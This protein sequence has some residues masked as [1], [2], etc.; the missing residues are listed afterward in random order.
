MSVIKDSK[1][2]VQGYISAIRTMLDNYPELKLNNSLLSLLNSNSPFGFIMNLLIIC[3]IDEKKLLNWCAKILCGS[4]VL[5]ADDNYEKT[6]ERLKNNKSSTKV[7]Q[8]ILDVIEYSIKTLLL[9]N[10]KDMFTCSI[11]PFIPNEVMKYPKDSLSNNG[12]LM[13]SKGIEISIPTIDMFNVLSHAPNGK[14]GK[15]LYFDN[16]DL[17]PNQM[18]KS[19]DFNA[20]LWYVINKGNDPFKCIWDNRCKN[21]VKKKIFNE[22]KQR[23]INDIFTENF[24]NPNAGDGCYIIDTSAQTFNEYTTKDRSET[25]EERKQKNS[26]QKKQYILVEYEENSTTGNVP[27][28]LKFYVNADRYRKK[29]KVGERDVFVNKTVFEFNYDYIFS[30]KLFDSKTIVAHIVNSLIGI[31]N[32]TT[33]ALLNS[34]FTLDRKMIE[35]KVGEVIMGLIDNGDEYIN[36]CSFSFSNEEYD[37]LLRQS[38][39]KYSQNYEFGESNNTLSEEDIDD[40]LNKINS[41]GGGTLEEEQTAISNVFET[42]LSASKTIHGGEEI[43]L[44]LSLDNNIIFKLL[45]LTITEIVL[46]VLSPKV[47]VLYAIN[48]YFMGDSADTKGISIENFMKGFSNLLSKIVKQVFEII[49]QELLKFLMEQI[50]ELIL[51]MVEKLILEKIRFFIE[52]IKRLLAL[53][54]MF[55]NMFSKKD[56]HLIDNVNYADIIVN[57]NE[58][59]KPKNDKC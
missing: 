23:K 5:T 4:E 52:L 51:L 7:D 1:S 9:L 56:S 41:I 50:Q 59:T 34:K 18:W 55:G 26:I 12:G 54:A 29:I 2:K 47:M 17:T 39:L 48:S 15:A 33:A 6:G 10:I 27:E 30:L 53:I 46:Q 11:N 44:K 42:A 20:F 25:G 16:T 38:E 57:E 32:S 8:G 36:D 35:G 22:N 31:L 14:Y 28:I 13:G 49:M 43:D 58:Q 24:F 21:N 37:N 19:T 40:L 45:K 3:G